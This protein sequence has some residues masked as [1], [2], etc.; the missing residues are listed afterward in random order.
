MLGD[1]R[2]QAWMPLVGAGQPWDHT[3]YVLASVLA[4]LMAAQLFRRLVLGFRRWP[5]RLGALLSEDISD[6]EKQEVAGEF[7]RCRPCCLDAFSAKLR[8]HFTSSARPAPHTHRVTQTQ[9]D[10]QTDRQTHTHTH[11]DTQTHTVDTVTYTHTH[12]HT[13]THTHTHTLCVAHF[14]HFS[15][16]YAD[17]SH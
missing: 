14:T 15:V 17:P 7:F 3:S 4:W 8:G 10:R 6:A 12:R 1:S 5:W 16:S 13:D 9:T 2:L 11:T